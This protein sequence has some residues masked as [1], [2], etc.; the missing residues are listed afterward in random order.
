MSIWVML[1]GSWTSAA[2]QLTGGSP[3]RPRRFCRKSARSCASSTPTATAGSMR[4]SGKP[5]APGWRSAADRACRHVRP[6]SRRPVRDS[7]GTRICP[8]H[9]GSS[10][11]ARRCT[12]WQQ[13]AAL[14]HRRPAH[15]LP[16]VRE[17]RVGEGA[18]GVLQHRCRGAGDADRRRRGLSGRWRALPGRVV[19]YVRSRGVETFAERGA[20][21][22]ARKSTASGIPDAQPAERQQRPDLHAGAVVR[23]SEPSL[24][25][26]P[27]S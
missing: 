12:V 1:A 3:R 23:G 10:S 8:D 27:E 5:R 14:R 2:A 18:G 24:F 15:H 17:R 21:L 4:P 11:D 25:A 9:A 22:R 19:V 13:G 26:D 16:G 7:R 20:R 6:R